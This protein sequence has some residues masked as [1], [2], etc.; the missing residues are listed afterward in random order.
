MSVLKFYQV[1]LA[2]TRMSSAIVKWQHL[3]TNTIDMTVA[4]WTFHL[5]GAQNSKVKSVDS[6]NLRGIFPP[7][8]SLRSR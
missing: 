3:C 5:S 4:S 1:N 7:S 8:F 6:L 2:A